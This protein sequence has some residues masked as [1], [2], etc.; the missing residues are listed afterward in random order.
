MTRLA[1]EH[2]Q[3]R[4]GGLLAL[5]DVSLSLE[6]GVV[7][8]LIGPNGSGKSTFFNVVSGVLPADAG[9]IVL[10]GAKLHRLSAVQRQHRGLARTF[11]ENQLFYDMTVLENALVGAHRG[12]AAGI[13]GALFRPALDARRR[14]R[15]CTRPRA[16]ASASWGLPGSPVNARATSPMAISGGWRSPVRW[17][18]SPR[19]CCSMSPRP[20]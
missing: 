3:K 15:G 11:Q 19:C 9:T 4:F 20:A 16:N 17:P 10:D 5:S 14:R 1:V 12:G 7:N 13:G 6:P 8:G 2:L 18:R